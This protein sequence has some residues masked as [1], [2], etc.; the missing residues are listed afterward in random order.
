MRR[1]PLQL[2]GSMDAAI[3]AI[4]RVLCMTVPG[5]G[6]TFQCILSEVASHQEVHSLGFLRLVLKLTRRNEIAIAQ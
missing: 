1:A 4:V 3:V 5:S 6:A 2:L